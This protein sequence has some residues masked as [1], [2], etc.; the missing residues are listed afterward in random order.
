DTA[1]A[2][3]LGSLPTTKARALRALC[4]RVVVGTPASATIRASASSTPREILGVFERAFSS[5]VGLGFHYTD[6]DGKKSSRRIEPHG[7]LAQS[8]VWYVLARDIDKAEPRMF[9]M[10]R[11]S[12]PRLLPDVTFHPDIKVIQSQLADHEGFRPLTGRWGSG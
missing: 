12:R 8:P 6:R 9:R 11:M 1:L 5:G 2:K 10:D 7:L 4:R 3:L